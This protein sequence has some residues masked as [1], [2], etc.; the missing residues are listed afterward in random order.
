MEESTEVVGDWIGSKDYIKSL[1]VKGIV[2]ARSSGTD[3]QM[4][5]IP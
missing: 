1:V 3:D 4:E 5:I 2:L